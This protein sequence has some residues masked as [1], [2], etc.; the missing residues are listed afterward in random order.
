MQTEWNIKVVHHY[1]WESAQPVCGLH[2]TPFQSLAVQL[3]LQCRLPETPFTDKG[4]LLY[5][6]LSTYFS[7]CLFVYLTRCLSHSICLFVEFIEICILLPSCC[8]SGNRVVCGN[9][10]KRVRQPEKNRK[11]YRVFSIK[12][13]GSRCH[14][15]RHLSV[16]IAALSKQIVEICLAVYLWAELSGNNARR[17]I[18][19]QFQLFNFLSSFSNILLIRLWLLWRYVSVS[20]SLFKLIV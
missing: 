4:L 5:S 19:T 3:T 9:V 11:L 2:L 14:T 15:K 17:F 8:L 16:P 1:R 20:S 13:T 6:Y 18:S 7:I 12:R 10:T